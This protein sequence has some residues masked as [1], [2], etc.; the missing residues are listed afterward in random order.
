MLNPCEADHHPYSALGAQETL[1]PSDKDAS[2]VIFEI[3]EEVL[4]D[5]SNESNNNDEYDDIYEVD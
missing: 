5:E 3:E 2:K 4:Y 1:Y